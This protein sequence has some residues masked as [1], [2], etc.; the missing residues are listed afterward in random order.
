MPTPSAEE[1]EEE[2]RPEG[3]SRPTPG[4]LDATAARRILRRRE[5]KEY[6]EPWHFTMQGCQEAACKGLSVLDDTFSLINTNI[7]PH[8]AIVVKDRHT[9]Y[10]RETQL[11]HRPQRERS[12]HRQ[13]VTEN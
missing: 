10:I 2:E 6:T 1:A 3:R 8:V 9:D 13:N 11:D 5:N 4:F 7:G 12:I